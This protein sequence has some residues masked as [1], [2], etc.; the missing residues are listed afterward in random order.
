MDD[1]H[2]PL[3]I[4]GGGIVGLMVAY[5]LTKKYPN[6]E[7]ALLE[8]EQYLGDHASGRNSGVLHAGIYYPQNSLKHLLCIE[9]N[10]LWRDIALELDIPCQSCGKFIVATSSLE[11]KALSELLHRA[12]Q[13]GVPG[14]EVC[15]KSQLA[16]LQKEV[17]AE[18]A[19]YAPST[20]IIDVAS[21]IRL[22]SVELERKG[23]LLMRNYMVTNLSPKEG[24]RGFTVQTNREE[25]SCDQVIN[26]AG[27]GAIALRKTLGLCELE[28]LIIK[29]NYLRFNGKLATKSLIY[30]VPA[31]REGHLGVHSVLDIDGVVRFGPDSIKTDTFSYQIDDEVKDRMWPAIHHMFHQVKYQQLTADFAGIRPKILLNGSPHLDFWLKGDLGPVGYYEA[32]GIDSPGLTAAPAIARYLVNQITINDL[33]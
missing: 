29:G 2:L 28:S 8:Q 23:V 21:A 9:G 32:C 22:L 18:G 7:F 25:L 4:V 33:N 11:M 17:V 31:E 14:I 13:N 5:Q 24:G 3:L 20:A 1:N 10:Q 26:C 19:I 6:L 30:P 15:T 16:I 27:A 12:Q